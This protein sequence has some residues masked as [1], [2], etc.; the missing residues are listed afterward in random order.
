MGSY[1]ES[2]T[3]AA[4]AITASAKHKVYCKTHATEDQFG[5]AATTTLD[6]HIVCSAVNIFAI[7]C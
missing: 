3:A 2:T 5:L 7:R 1:A 6:L 4:T